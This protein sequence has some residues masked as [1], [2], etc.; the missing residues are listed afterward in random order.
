MGLTEFYSTPWV[1]FYFR[2]P[3]SRLLNTA[4]SRRDGPTPPRYAMSGFHIEMGGFQYAAAID[5]RPFP[6]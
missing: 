2:L 1:I 4:K 6:F 5:A 3:H